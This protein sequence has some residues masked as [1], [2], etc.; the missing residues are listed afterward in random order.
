MRQL[1]RWPVIAA[2]IGVILSMLV[3]P[4][5]TG[6]AALGPCTIRWIGASG[7]WETAANW[8]EEGSAVNRVPVATDTVCIDDGN[9]LTS[10]VVTTSERQDRGR[11][12]QRRGAPAGVE[13]RA[14]RGR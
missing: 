1:L 9:P 12:R 6:S 10:L 7:A 3:V 11:H 14:D 8:R 13:R 5:A 4:A 2:V